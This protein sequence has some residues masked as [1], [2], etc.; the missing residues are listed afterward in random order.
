VFSTLEQLPQGFDCLGEAGP[1]ISDF[2]RQVKARLLGVVSTKTGVHE[3]AA[4][5]L[6]FV[7]Q[8]LVRL[9]ERGEGGTGSRDEGGVG[10]MR[11]GRSARVIM[12]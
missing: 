4:A 3:V 5:F 1:Q 9:D 11:N 8:F 7:L 10:R 12:L 6:V 2:T